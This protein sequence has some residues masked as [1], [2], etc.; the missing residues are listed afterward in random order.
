MKPI[1]RLLAI[2]LFIAP[3]VAGAACEP[4]PA[5]FLPNVSAS[6]VPKRAELYG[7]F[8]QVAQGAL[9]DIDDSRLKE[10]VTQPKGREARMRGL[11]NDLMQVLP[12]ELG[13]AGGSWEVVL[14]VVVDEK[15]VISEIS[16][17]TS[18]GDAKYDAAAIRALRRLKKLGAYELDKMPVRAFKTFPLSLRLG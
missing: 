8:C 18:S 7:A 11:T 10:R 1:A 4:T 15:G 5:A 13:R 9:V 14:A 3:C 2:G 6:A 12:W 16:I 17:V